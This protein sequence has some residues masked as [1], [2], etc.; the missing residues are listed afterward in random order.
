MAN[1]LIQIGVDVRTNIKQATADLDKMG[2]S[3]VNNINTIN[4]LESEV[5]Q[6]N[7][8]LG[9]GRVTEAAYA[10]GMRQINNELSIFQQRAAK[11]AEVEQKFGRTAATG[12][13]SLNRFNMVL[14]QGGY[15]LQDF[16][17]QLQSG[18]NF[19]TAFSQQGSQFASIFGPKGAV[20]GAV[21]ALGSA[22][23]GTLVAS[24]LGAKE[25]VESFEDQLDNLTDAL[26]EY[27]SLSER[28]ADSKAL[29]DEFGNLS[30]QAKSILETLQLIQGITLKKQL[31]ELGGIGRVTFETTKIKTGDIF[32][33]IPTFSEIQVLTKKQIDA[34]QEFLGATEGTLGENASYAGQY[35][36]L[37]DK[38]Q[39]AETLEQQAS[40]AAELDKFLKEHVEARGAE[41]KNLEQ[42]TALQNVLLQLTKNQASEQSA[43]SKELELE[44]QKRRDRATVTA[45]LNSKFTQERVERER[46]AAEEIQNTQTALL[47]NTQAN[48]TRANAERYEAERA[49]IAKVE[50]TRSQ[51]MI[52]SLQNA[53]RANAERIQQE[54]DAAERQKQIDNDRL[55]VLS[56]LNAKALENLGALDDS[57]TQ[58]ERLTA[59]LEDAAS[60]MSA[61]GSF[62]LSLQDRLAQITAENEA[63]KQ[64]LNGQIAGE[65]E[66][67]KIKRDRLVLSDALGK[68]D[69]DQMAAEITQIDNLINAYEEQ[70]KVNDKLTT[71]T[72]TQT[73]AVKDNRTAYEKAMMTATEFADAL[74]RQ[75]IGAVDGV[76]NAFSDFLAGGLKDFK[77]FVGSIKDMF[78]R[79]LADMAAMA[80]KQ[81][82]IIPI[83]TGM[84]A[85]FGSSAAA[86]TMASGTGSFASGT[87]GS[88]LAGGAS[89]LGSGFMAGVQ[90]FMGGGFSGYGAT[91]SATALNAG[92]M[93]TIGAALPA[94]IAVAAVIGLLTKKTKL[95]DSGL[96]ATVEGFDVAIET[97]QLTQSSRLFGL[98]KGRKKTA[99]TAADAELAD[100]LVKAIGDMQQS[101]VDA[102]GTLGIGAD[103]FDDFS[104]QFKVSLKGLTEEEQ[105][106]KV[107][108][109]ITKMG[110]AFASLS[111]H[112]STMNELL[113]VAQQRYDLQTRLLQL[114]GNETDLLIRQREREGA[115]THELNKDILAQIHAVED[116]QIAANKAQMLANEA[117]AQAEAA[118]ATVQRSIQARKEVITRSFNEIMETIQNRIEAANENVSISRGILSSLEGAS[119]ARIGMSRGAGLAYLRELRG[120]SRI[121]DE[122]MLDE[123]LQAVADPSE[124]LY[125]NFV[126]YQR[127]FA[128]QSNLIR[129]IEEKARYQLS[130]DEATLLA[131]QEEAKA[132]E[133]RYEDQID[134]LDNQLE[135]A[136][137][138]INQLKGIDTSVMSVEDAVNKLDVTISQAMAAQ[139]QAISA[140]LAAAA[141]AAS[142]Q[143]FINNA[144]GLSGGNTGGTQ[145]NEQSFADKYGTGG[146]YKGYDLAELRGSGDLKSAAGMLG[147]GT[148]GKSGAQ[149][150]QEIANAS[151]LAVN[152]DNATRNQKFAMGGMFG[153]GI[154]MVG[155]RGPEIEATG[156][157]R[158]FSTKQTAELFR[159]PELVEEVRS[160]R[161]EVAGLRSEQRQLQASNSKYVKRN[162]DINRKWDTEGLPA[163]RT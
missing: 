94:V 31:S 153:G 117:A 22:V 107:N 106:Q 149:I 87:V 74:D 137:D 98:L 112:F 18:T 75:V 27:R 118:F 140:A 125:K 24:F 78:I 2:G 139:T 30:G 8:E 82:I 5:A 4:R 163:T 12:G 16:V 56:A 101:I 141:A 84:A 91:L 119:S 7:R 61:I 122:K 113:Q 51:L 34:A 38:I 146:T 6:L 40:A 133:S 35:L 15:Q 46:Q 158:I 160:L 147:I 89:A 17:V 77:S 11:A 88:M 162:Y 85:G 53:T 65:I 48:A 128:D 26:E 99:Y 151:G 70:L 19:F 108:E 116:A 72:R 13:K 52:S 42:I 97:F 115:A 9:R 49:E 59:A 142:A 79:L 1:D 20:I 144:G 10:K 36:R 3:V 64:G 55:L 69:R 68:Q 132:A 102:A 63:I 92:P 95:L 130:T 50:E 58:A 33:V 159:N 54:E 111:G 143:Q 93:A 136:Q 21:I 14:Q 100:P 25:E 104:Y 37:L 81:R 161:A 103:A 134:K 114:T 131:I 43:A 83:A 71:K 47:Q 73:K 29:S 67:L 126:D 57:A 157:S 80:L 60:A 39:S 129:E 127:D 105:L 90:G 109:E 154:R 148:S 110:D 66:L 145:Q 62:N 150:Q 23:G 120:A 121:T 76:A 138:Q 44:E 32:G 86:Q 96:R 28:I 124:G 45:A 152:L 135:A 156:P 41:T 123:A 155:E